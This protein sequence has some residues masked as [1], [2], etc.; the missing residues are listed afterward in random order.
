VINVKM[1]TKMIKNKIITIRP[2][3]DTV[4]TM[5][6]ANIFQ[7]FQVL[8]NQ[9]NSPDIF[10]DGLFNL[11][12]FFRFEYEDLPEH[13]RDFFWA[14]Y[15]Q[16]FCQYILNNL[17]KNQGVF[18]HDS[19]T[20]EYYT[21]HSLNIISAA[22][23]MNISQEFVESI[24]NQVRTVHPDGQK[25]YRAFQLWE[26]FELLTGLTN[27]EKARF[28]FLLC[29]IVFDPHPLSEYEMIAGTTDPLDAELNINIRAILDVYRPSELQQCLRVLD[30]AEQGQNPYL[31]TGIKR[32]RDHQDQDIGKE[33]IDEEPDIF[34]ED[35]MEM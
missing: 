18:L 3:A 30:A 26:V 14:K 11:P 2:V 13:Q 8:V 19:R 31:M 20:L 28:I 1:I 17:N 27:E 24:T 35:A 16:Y 7:R 32:E 5:S 15:G 23:D 29:N 22:E 34:E 12:C 9:E 6:A 33:D 10:G 4:F 21:F 25:Y